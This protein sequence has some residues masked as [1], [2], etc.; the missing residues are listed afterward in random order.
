MLAVVLMVASAAAC[1]TI[2]VYFPAAAAEKAADRIIDEVWG[3]GE[4]PAEG[5]G[6]PQSALPSALSA[7]ASVASVALD[8][9]LPA[10]HAQAAD[11]DVSSPSIS[12]IEDSMQ[13]RH[14]KLAPFYDSGAI[15]LAPN[16]DIAVRDAKAAP[17]NQ[18]AVVKRLV[19]ED[20]ADRAALYREIARANGHPE[21][22]AQIRATFARRWIGKAR[23]GWWYQD[24]GSWK[25]R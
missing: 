3:P 15:G 12:R 18:R 6:T 25:Q 16:G 24:G 17:L 19:A 11:L 22:E 23:A 7:A 4:P 10:A 1:V 9:V 21:W 14:A 20:N 2:N 13:A 5:T 8:L